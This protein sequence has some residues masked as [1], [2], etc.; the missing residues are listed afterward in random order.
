MQLP[1]RLGFCPRTQR[2][3]VY[4]ALR[5]CAGRSAGAA[6][7]TASRQITRKSLGLC[8][9]AIASLS[10]RSSLSLI[11]DVCLSMRMAAAR[12]AIARARGGINKVI[13]PECHVVASR[14]A[15]E[16][17]DFVLALA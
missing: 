7:T 1:V 15:V 16:V 2:T 4:Q 17:N 3:G 9:T 10:L 13:K 14:P 11:S 12:S 5:H 6:L 8:S